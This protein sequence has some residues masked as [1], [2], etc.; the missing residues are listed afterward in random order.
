MTESTLTSS[1]E[2][3]SEAEASWKD[4]LPEDV[5]S[6]PSMQAIQTVDNLAKSYVNAQKMIGA[7]KIMVP[8][9][10]AEDN[11]W[12]DVF[13]KL[14]LPEKVDDYELSFKEGGDIDKEFFGNFKGAAHDAGIL[15]KQAQKLFDWYNKTNTE[16][17][18]KYTNDRKMNEQK[19]VDGL[20]AEW[21]SAY[22]SKMKAAKEAVLH[23]GDEN[24]KA[25]LDET[26]LGNNP[27]L[28]KTFSKMGASLTEDSFT[29]GGQA[30]LG[31]SPQ[32]AQLQINS[33]MSDKNHPYHDKHNPNHNNAVAEVHKLFQHIG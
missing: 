14:G 2:T 12:K 1:D 24:L 7:D 17:V 25:F 3:V 21:G 9:K 4:A 23:Y 6:D 27:N 26:G 15:P 32:D 10:Y 18:D 33:I 28:I 5:K 16:M 31:F 20:K 13:T 22:D 19:S 8:N 30:K 29:D 11:E